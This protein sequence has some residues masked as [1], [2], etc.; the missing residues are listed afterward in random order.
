MSID[1]DTISF[2]AALNGQTINLVGGELPVTDDLTINGSG[3]NVRISGQ[4]FTRVIRINTVA[5]VGSNRTATLNGLRIINGNTV[6][7]LLGNGGGLLIEAGAIAVISSGI[8]EDNTAGSQ[9]G[10]IANFGTLTIRGT[11]VQDNVSQ[12]EGGGI[13]NEGSLLV[14]ADAIVRRNST[15]SASGG[16]IRSINGGSLNVVN[17]VISSNS[18]AFFGGGVS[19]NGLASFTNASINNNTS[20]AGGGGLA[21][22]GSASHPANTTFSGGSISGNTS[23]GAGGGV[24][25]ANDGILS[26]SGLTV[27]NNITTSPLGGGGFFINSSN[28]VL[29]TNVNIAANSGSGSG[30]GIHSVGSALRLVNSSVRNN[31]LTMGA[32]DGGGIFL[33]GGTLTSFDSLIDSNSAIQAGGGIALTNSAEATLTRTRI[34]NNTS[35]SSGG[36]MSVTGSANVIDSEFSGNS[37]T[38]GAGIYVP[39]ASSLSVTRSLV[40]NNV[41]SL[42]GGGVHFTGLTLVIS[43]STLSGNSAVDFGGGLFTSNASATV[44]N[45]TFSNNTAD[46][47]LGGVGGGGGI[48]KEGTGVITIHNSIVAGNVNVTLVASADAQVNLGGWTGFN[49]LLGIGNG[50]SDLVNAVNG[51]LV[52]AVGTPIV[53][54]LTAL[55]D[56][57]GFSRVH[58]LLD[59]SP[60]INAGA[61]VQTGGATVDQ[62]GTGYARVDNTVVD[63]GAYETLLDIDDEISEA[64]ALGALNTTLVANAR[65][66]TDR[67]VDMYSF[68]VAFMDG[69]TIDLD[70]VAPATLTD[71]YIRLFDA[72]GNLLAENDNASAPGEPASLDSFLTYNFPLNGTYYVAVSG[73]GNTTYDP[74]TGLKDRPGFTGEYRLELSPFDPDD[75]ISEANNLNAITAPVTVSARVRSQDVDMFR[76]TVTAGQQLR[77]DVDRTPGSTLDSYLRLFNAAGT[78]LAFSDNNAAPGE[79]ASTESFIDRTFATAG[80][81]YIAVSGKQNSAYNALTGAGDVAASAGNYQLIISPVAAAFAAP[82]ISSLKKDR[83]ANDLGSGV[84]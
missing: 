45:S 47:N 22:V 62:R 35:T 58:A 13:Y 25:L 11:Q 59:G 2:A 3:T 77:F 6:G 67:D 41:A 81:F 80:T 37:S 15:T 53:P 76:F 66:I 28:N 75:Q 57:G 30:A 64:V 50:Q 84:A 14:T 31:N 5:G 68:T 70:G 49:N 54:L 36:G 40:A 23:S 43:N 46:S 8:V 65:S 52:G 73:K 16:G 34:R 17:A 74:V 1:G 63:I 61:N 82:P 24:N 10:G 4:N 71:S 42:N 39:V 32:L 60:A 33:S 38:N 21:T 18:A 72:S 56:H 83:L 20:S 27:A 44:R 26:A 48:Y 29:L 12:L 19:Y 51:N 79:P 9:G 7:N 55:E 69:V 78:Q